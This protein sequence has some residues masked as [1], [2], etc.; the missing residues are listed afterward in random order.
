M[1]FLNL[2]IP[3]FVTYE[4]TQ[5]SQSVLGNETSKIASC[6]QTG[7]TSKRKLTF[8]T[9]ERGS[10]YWDLFLNFFMFY[11]LCVSWG[12]SEHRW[13]NMETPTPRAVNHDSLIS[14][15]KCSTNQNQMTFPL[16]SGAQFCYNS[17]GFILQGS[18]G[19]E[20]AYCL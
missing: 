14:T 19:L 7:I 13:E 4:A 18:G 20:N 12:D 6:Y 11:D 10:V 1:G 16:I 5:F 3:I 8:Q 9:E 2:E 17:I 15:I